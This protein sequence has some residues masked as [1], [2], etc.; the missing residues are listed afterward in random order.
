M[1]IN[2]KE[3]HII[4]IDCW[5]DSTEKEETL[6][7]LIDKLKIYGIEIM[8]ATHKNVSEKTLNKVDYYIFDKRNPILLNENFS[9][10]NINSDRWSS[11]S[12]K[13]V[14]NKTPF[15][16]DYSIW[17][18][19]KNAFKMVESLNKEYIHFIEYD[20]LVNE[21]QYKQCFIDEIHKFDSIIYEYDKGST[22]LNNPYCA[23]Y[24]FSIKTDV[25]LKLIN[26]INSIEEYFTNDGDNWQLEKRF[27]Q[28]LLTVSNNI[29]V[30]KYVDNDSGLNIH[31]VWNR[32]QSIKSDLNIEIYPCSD[33]HKKIYIHAILGD[34][35]YNQL[36]FKHLVEVRY[37]ETSKFIEVSNNTY[38]LYEIGEFVQNKKIEVFYQGIKIF[39]QNTGE[40]YEIFYKMNRLETKIKEPTINRYFID[41]PFFEILNDENSEYSIKFIDNDTNFTHYSTTLNNNSW[42]KCSIKYYVNWRVEIKNSFG[43]IIFNDILSLNNKRVLISFES[44]SLGD[45]LAWMPICEQFRKKHNCQL[46]VST[47]W[48]KLFE[49][50]YENI[51]FV[52][53]GETV[54]DIVAQYKLGVF[55]VDG[56]FDDTRHKDDFK[57]LPLQKIASDIL[58]LEHIEEKPNLV[59][60]KDSDLIGDKYVCIGPHATA[61]AKY[62][63]YDG[64]W[65]EIIN[66]L[67]DCGYKVVYISSESLTDEW[68][69]SK[70]GKKPLYNVIDKSGNRPI[71]ERI[72]DLRGC[73][74]FIGVSSGLSWLAWGSGAKVVL[75]SG[76]TEKYLEFND[77]V[78]VINENVCHGCWHKHK[79]D[80]SDWRWCPEHKNS[81]REF[82][83]TKT[84]TSNQIIN[85]IKEL[86]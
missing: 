85:K 70:L 50:E 10:F 54:Y 66:Y 61:L 26:T 86:I 3:K 2:N 74:F 40:D 15:H 57:T 13:K 8:L 36:G 78:R 69:N 14:T 25:A 80:P 16:H 52:N 32:R 24:M 5:T 17:I 68:H 31:A 35:S 4:V 58:G 47:F 11:F 84:I 44:S 19:M 27:Y 76:F 46:I 6:I 83:C 41:G 33:E 63:N 56:K 73:E 48:N 75:I 72:A 64:G 82:E 59:K 43:D 65:Q 18:T 7:K 62:W 49:G 9:D 77:C 60:T 22:R 79:F 21:T 38:S 34:K 20:C 37:N 51:E 67:N 55:V 71:E 29:N 28:K 42:T 1:E 39:E 30:C 45:T 53:P 23:T 81:D 12:N